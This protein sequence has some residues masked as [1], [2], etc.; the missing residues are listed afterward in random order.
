MELA[1]L[2]HISV[3]YLHAQYRND[4]IDDQQRRQNPV[5]LESVRTSKYSA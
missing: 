2:K 5:T 3:G 4:W 1:A